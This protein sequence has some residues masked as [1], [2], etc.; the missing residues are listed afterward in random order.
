MFSEAYI[1]ALEGAFDIESLKQAR[2]EVAIALATGA[3]NLVEI[4]LRRTDGRETS[5]IAVTTYQERMAFLTAAKTLI[6][7]AEGRG[8]ANSGIKTDFSQVP[9]DP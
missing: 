1:D 2:N 4:N 7:R 6:D 8:A 3:K 9:V 5:A